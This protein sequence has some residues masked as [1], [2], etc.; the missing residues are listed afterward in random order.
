VR[1]DRRTPAHQ[2]NLEMDYERIRQLALQDKRNRKMRE[3]INGLRDEV[4]V[5]VRVTKDD[6]AALRSMR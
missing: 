3:W 2:A 1:L 6:V 4:Y 5:D